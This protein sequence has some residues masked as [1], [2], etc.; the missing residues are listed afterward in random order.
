MTA[1]AIVHAAAGAPKVAGATWLDSTARCA[2]CGDAAPRGLHYDAWAGD[3]FAAHAEL[4]HPGSP[5]VC[6]PCAW[7]T[8]W[9]APPDRDQKPGEGKKRVRS[10]RMYGHG[11]DEHR[12]YFSVERPDLVRVR[13]WL[14]ACGEFAWF[15]ALPTGGK[16]HLLPYTPVNPVGSRIGLVR[17]EEQTVAIGDWV[18][19]DAMLALIGQEV[20]RGE[21]E[22]GDYHGRS[23][24][25]SADALLRFEALFGAQRGSGWFSLSLH[26]AAAR[27]AEEVADAGDR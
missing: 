27:E 22:T 25:R 20:R 7:A 5:F 11:W 8:S 1:C 6:E 17:F 2:L 16:K 19:C 18:L 13:E 12:G 14:R 24:Q 3:N 10:L 4:A 23:W 26:L 21:I 15:C 9:V